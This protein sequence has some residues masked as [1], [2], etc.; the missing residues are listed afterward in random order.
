MTV[1][2]AIQ[3]LLSISTDVRAVAILDADG[4]LVGSGPGAVSTGVGATGGRLWEAAARR[5][6]SAGAAPLEHVV[7]DVGGASVAAVE[8]GG[9]RILAL[10]GPE[11]PVGLVLFDLRTCLTD[12]FAVD[13][14]KASATDGAGAGGVDATLADDSATEQATG[15][16]GPAAGEEQA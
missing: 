6:S 14:A 2:E 5:A 9:R 3:E 4:A 10:T 13:A 15:D 11:P 16:T 7:V 8:S 1:D 12:A